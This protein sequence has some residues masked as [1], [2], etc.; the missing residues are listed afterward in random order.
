MGQDQIEGARPVYAVKPNPSVLW[1]CAGD[2]SDNM[3][4]RLLGRV[5]D[6][7]GLRIVVLQDAGA[8]PALCS[9]EMIASRLRDG[10]DILAG[11]ATSEVVTVRAL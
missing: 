1:A 10:L 3:P 4:E 9:D 5:I 8:A 7:P 2:G 11:I 6:A